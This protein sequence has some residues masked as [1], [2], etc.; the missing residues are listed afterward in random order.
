MA[1]RPLIEANRDEL[2]LQ[3]QGHAAA[4]DP[5]IGPA[6]AAAF[7]SLYDDV[8]RVSGASAEEVVE[9]FACG[10][11]HQR[12]DRARAARDRGPALDWDPPRRT[13]FFCHGTYNQSIIQ[14]EERNVADPTPHRLDARAG[15]RRAVHGHAR[16]P[17]RHDRAAAH[18]R[19]PR[20]LAERARVDRQRVHAQLRRAA[21]DRRGAR[22]PLRAPADDGH[23]PDVFTAASAAAAPGTEHE[24]AD[25]GPRRAGRRR[26]RSCCR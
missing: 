14:L 9:F 3:M 19:R 1:Y 12:H 11:L 20:C 13:R 25:R 24:R 5:E 22:R 17:R 15:L 8:L 6:V 4:G 21:A 26:A 16:Q 2:L 18:P 10:M 7:K 23:R